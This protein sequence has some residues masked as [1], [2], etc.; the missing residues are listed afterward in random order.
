MKGS[1]KVQD[2]YFYIRNV[3]LLQK[4]SNCVPYQKFK[5]IGKFIYLQYLLENKRK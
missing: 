2:H 5:I 3:H 4:C 1:I